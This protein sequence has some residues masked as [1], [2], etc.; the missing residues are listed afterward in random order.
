MQIKFLK[1]IVNHVAGEPAVKIVDLLSNKKY[2]SEF[3][4]AKKLRLTINQTRNLLYK[5]SHLGILS[6]IRKKDKRKGWYIYF[7]TLN[8]LRSLEILEENLK[9]ELAELE[10]E[11]ANKRTKRFY[12][13]KICG[14]EINEEAALLDDFTCPECG[15]V[16]EL[17]ETSQYAKQAIKTIFGFKKELELIKQEREKEQLKKDEK[18]VR[19]LKKEEREK[20]EKR[21]KIRMKRLREKA[22]NRKKLEKKIKR[23]KKKHKKVLGKHK[24]KKKR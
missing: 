24:Q 7:W 6:S 20:K 23:V 11:L 12:K 15:E 13:C 1:Q 3:I 4:I 16:Y 17:L 9:K 19:S 21:R 22:R 8:V 2:L 5:L 10:N 18:L 14:V